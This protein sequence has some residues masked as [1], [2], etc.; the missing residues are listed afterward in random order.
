MEKEAAEQLVLELKELVS[1]K[2]WS[3]LLE[4][5][6]RHLTQ[7]EKVKAEDIRQARE[8]SSILNQGFIDGITFVMSEPYKIMTKI[9]SSDLEINN[10]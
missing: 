2:G 4:H 5:L 6:E 9:N 10:S 1:T 3:R 8:H 7:K